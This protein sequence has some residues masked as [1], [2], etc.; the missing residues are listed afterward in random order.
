MKAILTGYSEVDEV[1]ELGL[2]RAGV[3]SW[4]QVSTFHFLFKFYAMELGLT[5]LHRI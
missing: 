4:G 1:N 5:P 2:L 3:K